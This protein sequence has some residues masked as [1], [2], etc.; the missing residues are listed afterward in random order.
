MG[1][2]ASGALGAGAK[3][4]ASGGLKGIGTGMMNWA[5]T[6]PMKAVGGAMN[7]A[8]NFAQSRQQGQGLGGSA[9]SGLAGGAAALG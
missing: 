1:A 5:K 2:A 4:M 9:L 7:A 6:N 3:T 8:S